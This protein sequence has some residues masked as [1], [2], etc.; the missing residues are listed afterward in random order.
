[1][2][3]VLNYTSTVKTRQFTVKIKWATRVQSLYDLIDRNEQISTVE[4]FNSNRS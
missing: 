2:K 3:F 1:M 4:K